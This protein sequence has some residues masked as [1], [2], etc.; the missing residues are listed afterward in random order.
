MEYIFTYDK[1]YDH[2]AGQKLKFEI[3]G[4]HMAGKDEQK[5]AVSFQIITIK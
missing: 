5:S 1:E 3:Y 4:I 2:A